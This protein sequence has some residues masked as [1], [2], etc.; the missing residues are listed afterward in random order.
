MESLRN[1]WRSGQQAGFSL[2]EL[3]VTISIIGILA[4]V[5]IPSYISGQSFRRLNAAS[6]ALYS[7]L[8]M[9]KVEAVRRN[10]DVV[11]LFAPPAPAPFTSYQVFVDNGA[12]GGVAG[13]GILNGTEPVL[14][15]PVAMP[16]DVTPCTHTF[17]VGDVVGFNA[18]GLPAAGVVGTITLNSTDGAIRRI[19]ISVAGGIRLT[20]I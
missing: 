12:G 19:T 13:D 1:L 10:S 3:M 14:G 4:A 7:N 5:A 9:A 15:V 6:R 18:R 16:A 11:V 17:P 2:V 8:Q 20:D